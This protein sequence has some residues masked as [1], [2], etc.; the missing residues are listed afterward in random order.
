MNN[1]IKSQSRKTIKKR[2]NIMKEIRHTMFQI[3]CTIINTKTQKEN[4][5]T[6]HIRDQIYEQKKTDTIPK[7]I[8]NIQTVPKKA[9]IKNHIFQKTPC[10]HIQG[11]A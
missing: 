3:Y 6:Q 7:K 4:A 1:R 11:Q 8:T 10:Q 9:K 2:D 5:R